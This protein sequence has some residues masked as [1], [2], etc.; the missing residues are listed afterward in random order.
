MALADLVLKLTTE[1]A[2]FH[3]D[4]NKASSRVEKFAS[5]VNRTLSTIGAGLG[6]AGIAAFI[7][8]SIDAADQAL[9][10]AQRAG[11]TAKEFASLGYAAKLS[12]GDINQVGKAM[13]TAA[14]YVFDA[15][16]G[17]KEAQDTFKYL[18]IELKNLNG[19]DNA[20]IFRTIAQ[21][22][23]K[24]D[25][26]DPMRLALATRVWGKAGQDL[27]PMVGTLEE[28]EERFS[29]L[30]GL[31]DELAE[32]ASEFNDYLDDLK[33]T[34]AGIAL[35][36]GVQFTAVIKDMAGQFSGASKQV[37][38]FTA[39]GATLGTFLKSLYT[40]MQMVSYAVT[41]VGKDI[42]ALAA[43]ASFA[44]RFE[45][46][47]ALEVFRARGQDQVRSWDQIVQRISSVWSSAAAEVK[48]R[49]PKFGADFA[50]PVVEAAKVVKEKKTELQRD[51]ESLLGK[52]FIKQTE[53]FIR[54][55]E[56]LNR[57]LKAGEVSFELYAQAVAE[58]NKQFLGT[59]LDQIAKQI[60][61]TAETARV[62]AEH[63]RGT[64]NEIAQAQQEWVEA[65]RELEE[66]VLTPLEKYER[67][68]ARI[69]ELMVE[70]VI[71]FETYSRAINKASKEYQDLVNKGNETK[72]LGKE[73]GLVFSSAFED[74]V[75]EG[76]KLR[77]IITGLAKDIQRVIL[78]RTITEPIGN[79]FSGLVESIFSAKGNVFSSG[80]LVP[81]AAGGA[82]T[83]SVVSRPTAFS[84]G[85]M[86]E[87]SPE[88]IM[89]LTR[90]PGGR[91]GIAAYGGAGSQSSSGITI[92]QHIAIDAR[93][94]GSSSEE[95][96]RAAAREGARQGYQ[97]VIQDLSRAGRIAKMVGRA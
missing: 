66:S 10:L 26:S 67:E 48:S 86:G 90:G 46:S 53:D 91:L 54:L 11:T 70:G 19:Q 28:L 85:V 29:G 15:R 93:D 45:F 40:G 42:G 38:A 16:R 20:K 92:Q 34:M 97:M 6:A 13:K 12:G 56:E 35:R 95:R 73:L 89:P 3:A 41:E 76:K 17:L 82:F 4:L 96:L 57:Q 49:A 69:D 1:T 77:D 44:F 24:M 31:T 72:S 18:G 36:V 74:A 30:G 63:L 83:N 37:T 14:T 88:A 71:G 58:L 8:T 62:E 7:K 47:K 39:V 59:E 60:E 5:Q 61:D 78:R 32:Q 43:A 21:Q 94:L 87:K 25:E 80:S 33:T 2:S 52:T 27:L 51:I 84:I 81:F 23:A 9:D 55:N 50:S 75:I 65:G 79:F 68:L 64:M 22:L